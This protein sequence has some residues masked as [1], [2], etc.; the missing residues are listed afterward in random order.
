VIADPGCTGALQSGAATLYPP[1][2][3]TTLTQGQQMCI[4]VREFIP[5]TAQ[6][7]YTNTANV[8]ANFTYTNASPGL[9]A[10]YSLSDITTVSSSALNLAKAVRNVTQGGTF[11]VNNTAKSGEVLEYRITYTNN[12]TTPINNL[13]INDVTPNY[14]TFVSAA[15]D[16]TPATLTACSKTTPAGGP[17]ACATAQVSNGIGT[18][19]FIFTGSLQPGATG[20]VLFQVKV[21]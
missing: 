8:Q 2:V 15:A 7:G 14:T 18:L 10:T 3:A 13:S 6:N 12:G 4:I 16:V 1:S 19:S 17:I 9:S 5:A 11:G 21:N 20:D